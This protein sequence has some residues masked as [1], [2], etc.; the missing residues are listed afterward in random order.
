M[1]GFLNLKSP[2]TDLALGL[3]VPLAVVG[4]VLQ[5]ALLGELR[6]VPV[7][8]ATFFG[9]GA[10]R[11]ASGAVLVLV[12]FGLGGAVAATVIGQAF[13]TAFLLLVARREVFARGLDRVRISLRDASLSVAALAGYTTLTGIDTVLARHFLAPIAGGRYAAA[14]VAGHIAMFLPGALV[15]IAF[16]R[17]ASASATGASARKTLIETLALVTVIGLGAFAVLAA[18]PRLVVDVLFGPTYLGAASIVGII[19]L[20]S[21]LLG[22]IGLLTYFHVA[23]RSVAALNSWAGVALVWVTGGLAARR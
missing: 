21:V 15:T 13:A 12:G 20:I 8:V 19:A 14:A 23:R 5:G 1:D 4:A 6:F 22:I 9:G 7:A 16:P 17:L 10:L 2:A 11:L 3:W 18:T